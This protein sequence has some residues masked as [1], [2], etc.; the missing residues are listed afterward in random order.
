VKAILTLVLLAV[1]GFTVA[2]CGATKKA[3][4]TAGGPVPHHGPCCGFTSVVRSGSATGTHRLIIAGTQTIPNVKTGTLISCRGWNGR[5]VRVPQRGSSLEVGG[6][7][8]WM[9][10]R[11]E[12]KSSASVRMSLRHLGNG[13]IMVSCSAVE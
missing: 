6:G 11:R 2:G 10:T 5:F 9:I 13:A 4:V 12:T 3:G 7:L 8:L 1:L